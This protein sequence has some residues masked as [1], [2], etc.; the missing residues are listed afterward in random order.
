MNRTVIALVA[1]SLLGCRHPPTSSSVQELRI[2]LPN[3]W[4]T[5]L[6]VELAQALGYTQ[7]EGIALSVAETN[8][9]GKGMEALLGGSVQITA[10]TL[11]QSIS[12]AAEG[13]R[14]RCIVGLYT[15][16][17]V[18]VVVAPPMTTTI[19]TVRDL[20][21]RRVGVASAGSAS[22]QFLDFLLVSQGLTPQAVQPVSVGTAAPSLAA[23]EHGTV[24]AGV[25]VA[26]AIPTF[27]RRHP[28]ARMLVDTRP[29]DGAQRV[30]G[31]ATF[32]NTCVIAED[33]WLDTHAE[34]ARRFVRAVQSA[35]QWMRSHSAE[36]I[37]AR[38]PD[39]MRIPDGEAELQAIR[40][41]KDT[42]SPDGAIASDAAEAVRRYV[43]AYNDKVRNTR[44]DLSHTYTNDFVSGR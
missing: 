11:A 3:D 9:L 6:P 26:S 20:V 38:M 29:E 39:S 23:L 42:L 25:L 13:R 8:G 5:W 24:D 32:P 22:H 36:E 41:A 15:R 40:Q 44:V 43:A 7:Q 30:F 18:A 10:G 27:Q 19:R 33:D 21:G 34:S 17:A 35:M 1:L 2:A 14:L 16:P 4:I 12:L 37:R 31:T 28:E